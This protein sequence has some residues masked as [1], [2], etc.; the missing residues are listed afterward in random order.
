MNNT[1]F[2]DTSFIIAYAI[3]TDNQHTKTEPLED[4]I[5]ST[6]CC[7]NNSV[8]NECV[9]VSYN[10]TKSL[11]ISQEVYYIVIDNFKIINEYDIV[12]YNAKTM[13]VFNKHEGKLS[14]TDA[15][16]ITTMTENNIK[17]LLTFDKQFKK[18]STINVIDKKI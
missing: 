15:G 7:I 12:N 18:E 1:P 6:E 8:L 4:I 10:K 13:G 17:D 16:I 5:L 2:V 9:S 14:F 3:S 11:E